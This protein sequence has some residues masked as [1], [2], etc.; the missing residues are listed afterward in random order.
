MTPLNNLSRAYRRLRA[1]EDGGLSIYWILMTLLMFITVGLV[2]TV[3]QAL[4]IQQVLAERAWAAARYGA[5]EVEE[6]VGYACYLDPQDCTPVLDPDAAVSAAR[7]YVS[8]LGFSLDGTGW[9]RGQVGLSADNRR[10]I[11]RLEADYARILLPGTASADITVA[12]GASPQIIL[13]N[14]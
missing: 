7:A 13:K 11:V 10:V 6:T 4:S 5:S 12:V 8:Y 9:R 2:A 1:N 3:G 14:T